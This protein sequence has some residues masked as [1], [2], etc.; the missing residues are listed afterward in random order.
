MNLRNDFVLFWNWNQ[1]ETVLSF[2]LLKIQRLL[3]FQRFFVLQ[4]LT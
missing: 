1:F 4:S 2:H 3:V